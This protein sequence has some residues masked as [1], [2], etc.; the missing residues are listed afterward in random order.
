MQ[1]RTLIRSAVLAAACIAL[2]VGLG[3][4]ANL[5]QLPVFLDSIGTILSTAL[6]PPLFTLAVALMSSLANS[7]VINPVFLYFIGT[8][9]A[10]GLTAIVAFRLGWFKNLFAAIAAGLLIAIVAAVVSAPVV[11]VIFGGV[12]IPS[13]TAIN[14][15]LLAAGKGLWTSVLTGSLLTESIDKPISGVLVWLIL[16]RLP[17]RL[18][19]V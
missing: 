2:N 5:L 7:L 1:S 15:V 11:A 6:V 4:I 9:V 18:R 19:G 13:V 8:Q 3:K 12:T 17:E 10:I 16:R 14:A